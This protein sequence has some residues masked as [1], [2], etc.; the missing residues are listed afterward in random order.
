LANPQFGEH[1]AH[2]WHDLLVKRDQDNNRGI[3]THDVFL[4]WMSHQFNANRPWDDVV[5]SLLTAQGD[6]ALA[7]E[8]F[9]IL[10]NS[11]MGQPAPN[12]IVGTAAALFLGNQ[13]MCCE[14]H[15]H[16]VTPEWKPQDFWGLAAFFGKT[17]AHRPTAAK[18]PNDVLARITDDPPPPAKK[19]GPNEKPPGLADGS[20]PIPD[21]RNDGQYI[22][23]ARPKV[24]GGPVVA[25]A[26][27]TRGYAAEWF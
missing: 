17:R 5:R 10:A 13:L 25:R 6:Q 3:K 24:L 27:A 14:C 11:E 8:T 23:A 15:V 18:N 20:I 2:Y 12:K 4:R 16:P 9:F 26:T 19:K 21:P 22:G 1:F 7:G